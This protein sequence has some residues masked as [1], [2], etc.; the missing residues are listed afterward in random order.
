MMAGNV[1][2]LQ[3]AAAFGDRRRIALRIGVTALLKGRDLCCK[4]NQLICDKCGLVKGSPGC[5]KGK[6]LGFPTANLAP[7]KQIIPAEAVYAGFVAIGDS[8]GQLCSAD[9]KIPAA[10]SI[11]R[12]TTYGCDKPLAIEAHLLKD[13]VGDLA[14]QWMAM[15]FIKQSRDQIKFDSDKKLADRIAKDCENIKHLLDEQD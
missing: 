3:L 10:L 6:Q 4:Q 14:G 13:N 12:S 11:G 15:D 9:E 5:G 2:R 7:A 8:E 1:F